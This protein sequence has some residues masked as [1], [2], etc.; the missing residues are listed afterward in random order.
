MRKTDLLATAVAA[1][2]APLVAGAAEG[3]GAW[4]PF[5]GDVGYLLWT[6]VI[7][8]VVYW[9]LKRWAWGPLLDSLQSRE[10]FIE[11]SLEQATADR[12]AARA[13]LQEYEEK[14]AT[15]RDEVEEMLDEA[16]RDAEALRQREEE[17]ARQ[18]AEQIL[19]RAR[20]EIGIATDTAVK[21][22]Y[23]R[24]AELATSAA[25]K[26]LDRELSAADHEKLVAE[27]IDALGERPQGGRGAA[28]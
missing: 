14:L 20:R 26:I 22:L 25:G 8:L 4:S 5:Q 11:D 17:R 23:E 27:A 16:R 21:E 7:L 13:L 12:D 6:V 15:A 3:G 19:E 18:E 1:S 2:A 28:H 9:V 10:K 24:A